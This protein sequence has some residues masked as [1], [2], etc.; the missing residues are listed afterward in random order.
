[1]VGISTAQHNTHLSQSLIKLQSYDLLSKLYLDISETLETHELVFFWKILHAPTE[2][3]GK[4]SAPSFVALKILYI[5][6]MKVVV[7]HIVR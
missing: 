5:V 4:Y 6:T 1:L 7:F 2:T 3:S